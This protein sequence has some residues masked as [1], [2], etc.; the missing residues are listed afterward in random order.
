MQADLPQVQ[1]SAKR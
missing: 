1:R